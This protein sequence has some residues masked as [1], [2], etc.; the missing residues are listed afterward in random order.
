VGAEEPDSAEPPTQ[1]GQPAHLKE[2]QVAKYIAAHLKIRPK[3]DYQIKSNIFILPP[4][5]YS[6]AGH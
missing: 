5:H 4:T 2:G 6:I 1:G 3:V